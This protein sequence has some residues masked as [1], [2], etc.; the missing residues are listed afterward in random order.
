MLQL[1]AGVK[2]VNIHGSR[3]TVNTAPSGFVY[4]FGPGEVKLVPVYVDSRHLLSLTRQ[5]GCCGA[6]QT[7]QHYFEEVP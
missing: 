5:A 7:T 2:V 3:L 4:R 1:L 6:E